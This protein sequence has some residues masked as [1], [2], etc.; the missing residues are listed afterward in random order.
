MCGSA[1]LV[2]GLFL[3][4]VL[5]SLSSLL[6][7]HGTREEETVPHGLF[8]TLQACHDFTLQDE[9]GVELWTVLHNNTTSPKS[10]SGVLFMSWAVTGDINSAT[11]CLGKMRLYL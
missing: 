11:G 2:Q 5:L 1:L 6:L 9:C 7:Q 4:V 10:P 8:E 3:H